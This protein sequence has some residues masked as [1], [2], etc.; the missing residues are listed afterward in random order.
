MNSG[1]KN[2]SGREGGKRKNVGAH[3]QVERASLQ[4]LAQASM[5]ANLVLVRACPAVTA[6][7]PPILTASLDLWPIASN[8]GV[9]STGSG[10][11][12]LL[13]RLGAGLCP[14]QHF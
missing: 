1:P 7:L 14:S 6:L 4:M 11:H 2:V 8:F 13:V 3:D 10:Q 12:G 5:L 9:P